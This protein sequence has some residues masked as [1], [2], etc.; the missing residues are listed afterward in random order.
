[1]NAVNITD[2]AHGQTYD[3]KTDGIFIFV[4]HT[5]NSKVFGQQ[6]AMDDSGYVITD[7]RY[8]TSLEGVFAAG[9]IQDPIWKQVATSVGQGTSA[10]MSTI[11]WL[12]ENEHLL[13]PLDETQVEIGT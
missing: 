10:A 11:H 1:V 13:Q 9:E 8:R 4:G 2:H 5:P 6:L 7:E 3:F 12:E